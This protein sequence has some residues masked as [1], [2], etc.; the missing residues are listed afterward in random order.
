MSNSLLKEIDAAHAPEEAL[1]V[2]RQ[3]IGLSA[4]E[5]GIAASAGARTVRNWSADNGEGIVHASSASKQRLDDLR[6]IAAI[7][8]ETATTPNAIGSW[9]RARN[10][11]LDYERPLELLGRGEFDRVREAAL[12]YLHGMPQ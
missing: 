10:R 11:D 8:A 9:L 2:L 6:A 1:Y 4:T 7:I 12:S 5:L 3:R